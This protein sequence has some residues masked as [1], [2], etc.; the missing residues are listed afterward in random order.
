M[1]PSAI[2]PLWKRISYYRD[3]LL[4]WAE[5]E[6]KV[7]AYCQQLGFPTNAEEFVEQLGEWLTQTAADVDLAA[8]DNHSLTI[9]EKGEPSLTR[10]TSW[11]HSLPTKPSASSVLGIM[12]LIF[13]CF[14]H[15]SPMIYSWR[16]SVQTIH[17]P[18]LRPRRVQSG[19]DLRNMMARF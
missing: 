19:N 8:S 7:A 2:R 15:Q 10:R 16:S 6:P 18:G 9:S 5:C 11:R 4:S 14:L 1:A 3:Q 13:K 12:S 17:Y